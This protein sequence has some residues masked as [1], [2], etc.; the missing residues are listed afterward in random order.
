MWRKEENIF[1]QEVDVVKNKN[2]EDVTVDSCRQKPDVMW[3]TLRA[4]Y[5]R[6]TSL[7]CTRFLFFFFFFTKAL[8]FK[9][10]MQ[11]SLMTCALTISSLRLSACFIYDKRARVIYCSLRWHWYIFEKSN[12]SDR[13]DF[14][15]FP[16]A[17]EK[18]CLSV[19]LI[20]RR[21]L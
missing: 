2:L 17:N 7:S 18:Q 15:M 13:I 3:E 9:R 4:C 20:T 6:S 5:F 11:G 8:R 12:L 10:W 14:I 16:V 1:C 21:F 19:A